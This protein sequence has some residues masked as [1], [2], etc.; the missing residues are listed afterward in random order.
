MWQIE[1]IHE[2]F[3]C[4]VGEEKRGS[5]KKREIMKATINP[6]RQN[7]EKKGLSKGLLIQ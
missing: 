4:T 2:G 1:R 7:A 5:E 6:N 3:Y